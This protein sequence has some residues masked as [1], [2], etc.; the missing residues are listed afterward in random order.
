MAP[1]VDRSNGRGPNHRDLPHSLL[2]AGGGVLVLAIIVSL[3]IGGGGANE[4]LA[5]LGAAQT[6]LLTPQ[7]LSLVPLGVAAGYLS[8]LLLD[9]MTPARIFLSRPGGRRVGPGSV[10]TGGSVEHLLRAV[11]VLGA[12]AV[13]LGV[14]GSGLF[15]PGGGVGIVGTGLGTTAFGALWALFLTGSGGKD[16]HGDHVEHNQ[17]RRLNR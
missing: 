3:W 9:S 15:L 8:H 5:P 10:K 14:Y 6:T 12:A 7:N 13:F 11:L 1:D 16:F 17:G 2:Y 4:L